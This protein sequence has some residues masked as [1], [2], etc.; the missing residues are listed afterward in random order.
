[1]RQTQGQGR[2]DVKRLHQCFFFSVSCRHSV[3]T[4]LAG[5][6]WPLNQESNVPLGGDSP[7]GSAA[8]S[9]A[10]VR[11]EVQRC[12]KQEPFKRTSLYGGHY[13]ENNR[14]QNQMSSLTYNVRDN[15]TEIYI[16]LLSMKTLFTETCSKQELF[17]VK[18]GP[19]TW[20]K[21]MLVNVSTGSSRD[22]VVW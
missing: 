5:I 4:R 22:I 14:L 6:E 16:R 17:L 2:Y 10:V 19:H 9:V 15:Y 8:P 7:I 12:H 13:A 21:G 11:T 1:M 18:G 3:V 20:L